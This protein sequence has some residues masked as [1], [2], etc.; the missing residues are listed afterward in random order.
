[1]GCSG[2]GT[3]QACRHNGTT[4]VTLDKGRR[5]PLAS[6][7][8]QKPVPSPRSPDTCPCR[9][10]DLAS[11]RAFD[12]L[13]S[14]AR[15]GRRER[16]RRQIKLSRRNLRVAAGRLAGLVLVFVA[17]LGSLGMRSAYQFEGSPPTGRTYPHQTRNSSGW[18]WVDRAPRCWRSR[19]SSKWTPGWRRGPRRGAR[20][21]FHDAQPGPLLSR[22]L[23]W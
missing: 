13:G 9:S 1:M 20:S 11:Y 2:G 15:E 23:R 14:R 3:L 8:A 7:G 10:P 18:E 5:T 12:L 21:A 4:L 6:R 19:I 16:P 22:C 17:L